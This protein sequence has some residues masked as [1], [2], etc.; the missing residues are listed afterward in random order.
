MARPAQ[1]RVLQVSQG[2]TYV[3]SAAKPIGARVDPATM[4]L[5]GKPIEAKKTYRVTVNAF[6]AD[7]GDGFTTLRKGRDTVTGMFDVEALEKY[8]AGA[9]TVVAAPAMGRSGQGGVRGEP[10]LGSRSYDFAHHRPPN[11]MP[12]H[13]PIISLPGML[14]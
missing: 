12:T 11:H 13:C 4:K 1:A 6:L 5:G 7:G 2:F 3:W 8:I 10:I 14:S 9:G